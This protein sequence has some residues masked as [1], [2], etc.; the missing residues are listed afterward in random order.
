MVLLKSPYDNLDQL[1]R[2]TGCPSILVNR[3]FLLI[4][5]EA[6]KPRAVDDCKTSGL[7]SAF[8]Q[9]NKLVL[10]DLDAYAAMRAFV[11]SSVEGKS[12][13][14]KFSNGMTWTADVS[15][16]FQG[17]LEWKGKCLDLEKAYRQVSLH[18]L[19]HSVLRWFMTCRK[20]EVLLFTESSFWCSAVFTLSTG[21][22]QQ[23]DS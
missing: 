2:E 4:Q 20:T 18:H 8:T 22:L 19:W 13:S 12:T 5:G 14:M 3:R 7:N 16:D 23:Y 21:L 11:G 1:Q 15:R 17:V 6:G 9:N 10:Q